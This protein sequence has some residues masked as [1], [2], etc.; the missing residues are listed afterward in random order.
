MYAFPFPSLKLPSNFTF[1][2]FGKETVEVV[3]EEIVDV[4]VTGIIIMLILLLPLVGII[5][6]E[7][8]TKPAFVAFT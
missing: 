2:P 1:V 3:P 8:F 5:V 6:R 7:P 4:L